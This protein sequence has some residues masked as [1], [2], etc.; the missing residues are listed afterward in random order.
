MHTNNT[1][2]NIILIFYLIKRMFV[3]IDEYLFYYILYY[4]YK[5]RYYKLLPFVLFYGVCCIYTSYSNIDKIEALI[6]DVKQD[7]FI[8]NPM[9]ILFHLKKMFYP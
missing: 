4:L 9:D 8:L 1:N 6:V 3:F 2:N 5:N 7:I